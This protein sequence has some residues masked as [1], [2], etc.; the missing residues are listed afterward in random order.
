MQ[1]T[2]HGNHGGGEKRIHGNGGMI[3]VGLK[4][5]TFFHFGGKEGEFQ[6]ARSDTHSLSRLPS[7][8]K[9]SNSSRDRRGRGDRGTRLCAATA[10]E[11]K[12]ELPA[13]QFITTPAVHACLSCPPDQ[14]CSIDNGRVFFPPSFTLS[15]IALL[16]IEHF[17][18]VWTMII[19][20]FLRYVY[21]QISWNRKRL[22]FSSNDDYKQF[23]KICVF[24]DLVEWKK[25]WVER[26]L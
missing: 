13:P 22:G 26:W 25:T 4:I 20:S 11:S 19:E 17:S 7:R 23:S 18:V 9:I 6:S 24:P 1:R 3:F 10:N 16:S 12:H 5:T 15:M 2:I 8:A 21:F 14:L